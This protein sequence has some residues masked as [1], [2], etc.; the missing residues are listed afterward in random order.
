MNILKK[1]WM[2]IC[3]KNNW[4]II[5]AKLKHKSYSVSFN[6]HIVIDKILDK[7]HKQRKTYWTQNSVFYTC[8]IFMTWWTVYKNEK[9]IQKEW[10]VIDLQ[11]LNYVIIFDVYFLL[12]QSDII[13]SILSCKYISVMNRTDFFYQ[14]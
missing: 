14:W 7:L 5:N 8:L 4:E 9:F 3:F 1:Y 11:E 2:K 6:K 10:A 12:L 13:M